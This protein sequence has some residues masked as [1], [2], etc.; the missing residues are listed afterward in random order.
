MRSRRNDHPRYYPP[1]DR[2]EDYTP[3]HGT[4]FDTLAYTCPVDETDTDLCAHADEGGA[5]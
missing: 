2:A 4:A 5:A 3:D 1:V